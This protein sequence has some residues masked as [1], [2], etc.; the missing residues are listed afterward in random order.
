MAGPTRL[1]AA[2]LV[3]RRPYAASSSSCRR[4]A[5]SA[6]ASPL[7]GSSAFRIPHVGHAGG[8]EP[9]CSSFVPSCGA[10][11]TARLRSTWRSTSPRSSTLSSAP[12]TH[13]ADTVSPELSHRVIR[14]RTREGRSEWS[15]AAESSRA[16]IYT[17]SQG[18][19]TALVLIA[20]TTTLFGPAATC[21]SGSRRFSVPTV[22]AAEVNPYS[23][24]VT[25]GDVTIP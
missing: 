18:A 21:G 4:S 12:S 15:T 9:S 5:W 19:L 14:G 23:I 7:S 24:A 11:P 3:G 16:V 1:S 8:L 25:P 13:P 22:D 20:L 10:S 6:R 2:W 17:S